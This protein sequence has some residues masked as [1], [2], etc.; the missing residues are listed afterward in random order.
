MPSTDSLSWV[1]FTD[2]AK[3]LVSI[4]PELANEIAYCCEQAYRRGYQQG[5]LYGFGLDDEIEHWRFS[6]HGMRMPYRKCV[7]P[8]DNRWKNVYT[9]RPI[10]RL[11]LEAANASSLVK[12]IAETELP[13]KA[14]DQPNNVC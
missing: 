1:E 12:A 14:N 9:T 13:T 8:P 3:R 4:A 2:L 6:H 7:A 5:A 11:Q 10:Y